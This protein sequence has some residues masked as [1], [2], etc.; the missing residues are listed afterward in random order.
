MLLNIRIT[1]RV[2]KW[3]ESNIVPTI[4]KSSGLK[5]LA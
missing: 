5:K 2:S 3:L 1:D 4:L